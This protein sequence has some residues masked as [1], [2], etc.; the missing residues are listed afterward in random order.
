MSDCFM[1][2]EQTDDEIDA[3]VDAGWEAPHVGKT[4]I[5]TFEIVKTAQGYERLNVLKLRTDRKKAAAVGAAPAW[6]RRTN[7]DDDD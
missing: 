5:A 1:G 6:Q 4:A 2:H 7:D 3:L